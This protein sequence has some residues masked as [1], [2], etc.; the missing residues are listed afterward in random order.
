MW[1]I[2][3]EMSVLLFGYLAFMLVDQSLSREQILRIGEIMAQIMYLTLAV[4]I[5]FLVISFLI[6][7]RQKLNA[8][9]YRKVLKSSKV[10]RFIQKIQKQSQD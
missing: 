6:D 5:I 1:I 9:A 10:S 4:N 7:M 8:Y 3:S 2:I